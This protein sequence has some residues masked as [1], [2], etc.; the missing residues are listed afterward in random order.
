MRIKT[1]DYNDV[2]VMEMQGEFDTDIV[3]RF[4]ETVTDLVSRQRTG[5]VID[6]NEVGFIDSLALEKLLWARDYCNENNCQ[7]KLAGVGE[8]CRKILELTRLDGEFEWHGELA[9]AVKSFA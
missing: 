1:Q 2:T 8:N 6:V 4:Q 7:F 5:I 9:E 3:E